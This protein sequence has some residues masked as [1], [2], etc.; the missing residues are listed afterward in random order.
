MMKEEKS[1]DVEDKTLVEQDIEEEVK[2]ETEKEVIE[3]DPHDAE[4]LVKELPV[5]KEIEG[6]KPKTEL[7]RKVLN[8]EI[9]N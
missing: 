8:G 2:L 6:W 1:Q 5:K 9:K 4:E 3:D 7:G